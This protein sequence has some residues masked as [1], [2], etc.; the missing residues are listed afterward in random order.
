M[1]LEKLIKFVNMLNEDVKLF[2]K[3]WVGLAT[4]NSKK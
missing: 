4:P 3:A 2:I 1:P